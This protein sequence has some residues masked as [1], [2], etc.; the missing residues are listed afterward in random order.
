[1]Q[2]WKSKSTVLFLNIS[3]LFACLILLRYKHLLQRKWSMKLSLVDSLFILWQ[4]IQK[5]NIVLPLVFVGHLFLPRSR[6]TATRYNILTDDTNGVCTAPGQS[7]EYKTYWTFRRCFI[8][9]GWL[10]TDPYYTEGALFKM[11]DHIFMPIRAMKFK[12]IQ[13]NNMHRI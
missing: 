13:S 9:Q 4:G 8:L 12:E 10:I 7:F 3:R 5:S 2:T 6:S 1:M 11:I